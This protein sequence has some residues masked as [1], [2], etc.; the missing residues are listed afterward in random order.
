MQENSVISGIWQ[1]SCDS[2]DAIDRSQF[3]SLIQALVPVQTS[4]FRMKGWSVHPAI[5][6]DDIEPIPGICL[7]DILAEELD[8]H[9]PYGSLVV[10]RTEGALPDMSY[11]VGTIV[12]EALL[13]IVGRGMFPLVDEDCVLYVLGQAYHTAA[14]SDALAL[15]GLN[16]A[17]FQS[18]LGAVLAQYWAQPAEGESLFAA[19]AIPATLPV[20][21]RALNDGPMTVPSYCRLLPS[22]P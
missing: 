14:L 16:A 3:K 7:G 5:M 9:V 19:G 1:G 22:S 6:P 17:S 18:G 11:A 15:L 8:A 20:Q 21:L 10:F 12:G 13:Q 4:I 2:D